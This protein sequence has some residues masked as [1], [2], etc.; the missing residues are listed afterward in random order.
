MSSI[1]APGPKSPKLWQ[2]KTNMMEGGPLP[3]ISQKNH[4]G[5]LSY[6]L[7]PAT[8]IDFA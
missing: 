7:R 1:L 2:D 4:L 5:L 6:H 3:Q 8:E